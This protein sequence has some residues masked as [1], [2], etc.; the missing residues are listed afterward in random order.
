MKH[1]QAPWQFTGN[2]IYALEHHGWRKGEEVMQ[3]RFY[4]AAYG[5]TG[6]PPEEVSANIALMAAAPELLE[7]LQEAKHMFANEY[8]GHPTTERIFAAILK[9]TGE[10]A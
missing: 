8:P 1:T 7:A 5:A 3:N 9:A 10:Q 4:A 6:T 2:T